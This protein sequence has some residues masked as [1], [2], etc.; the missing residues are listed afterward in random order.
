MTQ[1]MEEEDELDLFLGS[2]VKTEEEMLQEK[3][4]KTHNA[5]SNPI[6]RN[7]VQGT[8]FLGKTKTELMKE[9]NL[10]ES[11]LKFHTEVLINADFVFI[12]KDGV[13]RLTELGLQVLPKL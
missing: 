12:D 5:A 6:R 8:G 10:D 3:C 11:T 4:E 1:K 9:T 13:Y 7:I 2:Q